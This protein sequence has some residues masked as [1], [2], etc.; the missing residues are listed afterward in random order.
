MAVALDEAEIDDFLTNGHTLI[1]T[2]IDKDGYPHSTPLW[3]VYMDGHIYTRGRGKSQ[4]ARNVARDGKVCCLVETG[5]LWRELKAVMVRGRAELLEEGEELQR[6]TDALTE[7][8][9][10][11]REPSQNLPAQSQRHYASVSAHWKV[12]PEKKMATWDNR[13]MRLVSS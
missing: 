4:K 1:F 8:Y 13:K 7:K 5:E 2:T 9:K 11:F 10:A 6:F 12:T 3:Y